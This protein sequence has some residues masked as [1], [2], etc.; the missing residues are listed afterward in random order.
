MLTKGVKARTT[1]RSTAIGKTKTGDTPATNRFAHSIIHEL[2]NL[3][4]IVTMD[5][6]IVEQL[7][8]W[9][10]KV[11]ANKCKAGETQVPTSGGHLQ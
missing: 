1:T 5:V 3:D 8:G 9:A 7:D 11:H 4:D 2:S 6:Q 10:H